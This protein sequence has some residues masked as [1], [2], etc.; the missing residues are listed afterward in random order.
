MTITEPIFFETV[1]VQ[2][3]ARNWY[4]EF[5]ENLTNGIMAYHRWTRQAWSPHRAF[6]FYFQKDQKINNKNCGNRNEQSISCKEVIRS[7]HSLT[8]Y[9]RFNNQV[10]KNNCKAF[11]I[12]CMGIFV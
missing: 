12:Y 7:P 4:T 5:H 8:N 3:F 1:L 2:L 10:M 9:G 11:E 6:S